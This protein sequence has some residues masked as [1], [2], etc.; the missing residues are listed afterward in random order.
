LGN[1]VT[2]I[3]AC[4]SFSGGSGRRRWLWV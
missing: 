4:L 1:I 2:A 3:G